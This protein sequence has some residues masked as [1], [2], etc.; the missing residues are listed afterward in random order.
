M[1]RLRRRELPLVDECDDQTFRDFAVY[2]FTAWQPDLRSVLGHMLSQAALCAVEREAGVDLSCP[3]SAIDPEDWLAVFQAY[4]ER[5]DRR[6]IRHICGAEA[7]LRR[8]Q[9]GLEKVHRTRFTLNR[10]R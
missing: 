9:A 10:A 7:R 8:Q 5:A 3:P 6:A 2:A 1:L 4:R